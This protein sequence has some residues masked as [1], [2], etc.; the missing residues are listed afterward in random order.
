R[1]ST[2]SQM[3]IALELAI[4]YN[5]LNSSGVAWLAD[6]VYGP[7]NE[8]ALRTRIA[9]FLCPDDS[10][11]SSDPYEL[12]HNNYRGNA[13]TFPYNLADDSADGSG[14]NDGMFWFQS[15]VRVTSITDGTSTTALFSERCIGSSSLPDSKSD[16][17][18][19]GTNPTTCLTAVVG[20]SA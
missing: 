19:N 3:L 14:R 10:D 8:T 12:G 7:Q 16:F 17:Y 5:S 4:V 11:W 20:V 13:G 18:L 2:H 15:A 9:V 6:P 1:W